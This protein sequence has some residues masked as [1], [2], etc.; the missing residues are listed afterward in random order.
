MS[1]IYK[2]TYVILWSAY[3]NTRKLSKP[4][5]QN[6]FYFFVIIWIYSFLLFLNCN[7]MSPLMY[8]FARDRYER[9]QFCA[10]FAKSLSSCQRQQ[11]IPSVIIFGRNFIPLSN[12]WVLPWKSKNR[13]SFHCFWAK[14]YLVTTSV[15][16]LKLLKSPCKI[17]DFFYPISS[18]SGVS[19]HIFIEVPN[20]KVYEIPSVGNHAD[21]W[22]ERGR[23][24][25][26][27]I[28]RDDKFKGY[29]L[30]LGKRA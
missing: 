25:D 8:I 4:E 29:F 20:I 19:R 26:V 11:C 27:R 15:N 28:E 1:Y 9:V 23:L 7:E 5:T 3:C 6:V 21:T 2:I 24:K 14:K 30:Y 10:P 22:G 17:Q 16:N 18:K 13:G 12:P